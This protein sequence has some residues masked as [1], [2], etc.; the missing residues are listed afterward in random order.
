MKGSDQAS[1]VGFILMTIGQGCFALLS[2][3]GIGIEICI[4][5]GSGRLG[6]DSRLISA[7]SNWNTDIVF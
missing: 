5:A 1:G 3:Y 6:S 2:D 7:N 4:Q